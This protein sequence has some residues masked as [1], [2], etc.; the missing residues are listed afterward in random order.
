MTD[1]ARSFPVPT[2]II[3]ALLVLMTLLVSVPAFPATYVVDPAGSDANPGD[4]NAPWATIQHAAW[5]VAPG[6]QVT[7]RSGTYNEAVYLTTSG[8]AGSPITFAAEPGVV[9]VTPNPSASLSAFDISTGVSY[10]NLQGI[11]ATGGY[12]ETIFLRN[13][14]HDILVQGCNL[15]HN[16]AGIIMGDVYNVTVQQCLL[17]ENRALGV[18]IAGA[19][20]DVVISHT[21][22][23]L[24]GDPAVC[25][26]GVDG[27]AVAA[28]AKAITFVGSRAYQNGGDGFDA[29]G[30]QITFDQVESSG[31]ACSGLK[32][33]Q[34]ADIRGSLMTGNTR[35]LGIGSSVGGTTV[36]LFNSTIANNNGVGMDLDTAW[37]GTYRVN[38]V[39]N[40]FAGDFKAI[41][42][43]NAVVFAE[44]NNI[45]FRATSPYDPVLCPFRGRPFTGHDI[46]LGLWARRSRQGVGTLAVDPLFV[47]PANGDFHVQPTSAAVGRG[48]TVGLTGLSN[49]LTNIGAY[50]EPAGPTNHTPWA[51]AGRNLVGHAKRMV[52]VSALG[53]LDPD[54]DPLTYAWDFGDGSVPILGFKATHVYALAGTYQVTLTASDGS[55]SG[56]RTIQATIR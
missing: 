55:L 24:N 7:I 52:R 29:K 8:A 22:S 33:W 37:V 4:S 16:H 28:S 42:Y 40:I 15:H 54:A 13:G 1:D 41:Q 36:N 38:V 47:D 53:S 3:W 11:E 44:S 5:A 51:D 50:A 12:D 49:T 25:D 43:S 2:A 6:D 10:L 46:N 23:F 19:A 48:M 18:R 32:I 35:G 26:A 27:F 20:H 45:F 9:L 34:S 31:N 21:D 39:N 56:S 14:V 17:H 30:D